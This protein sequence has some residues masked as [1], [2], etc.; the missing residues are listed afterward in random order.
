MVTWI[1]IKRGHCCSGNCVPLFETPGTVACQA[2]LSMEF[3]RQEDWSGWSFPPPG[4]LSHPGIKTVSLTSSALA[5]IFFTTSTTWQAQKS[6]L[7]LLLLLILQSCLTLCNPIDG[8]P[9]G[10]P[11]PGILQARIMEWVAIAFSNAW[12]WKVKVK[13]LSHVWLLTTSWTAAYQAPP[14]MAFSRQE[15]WSGVPLT[16]L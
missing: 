16:S 1:M 15:C 3:S 5:G 10:S 6:L 11:V 9:P 4:D 12:K 14:S 13:S 8:G 7:L 2:P